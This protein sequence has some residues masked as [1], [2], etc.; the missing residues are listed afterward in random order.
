MNVGLDQSG[1][2]HR[3]EKSARLNLRLVEG[4]GM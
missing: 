1:Q 3:N 2:L 4:V